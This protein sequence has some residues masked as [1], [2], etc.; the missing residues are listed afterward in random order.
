MTFQAIDLNKKGKDSKHP[1]YRRL[2][3]SAVDVPTIQEVKLLP[4]CRRLRPGCLLR[5]SLKPADVAPTPRATAF[6]FYVLP[7]L[8]QIRCHLIKGLALSHVWMLIPTC[9]L[10]QT[11]GSLVSSMFRCRVHTWRLVPRFSRCA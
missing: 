3:H 4:W 7:A 11:C 8:V 10:K 6:K 9:W 5:L 1:M 2:V